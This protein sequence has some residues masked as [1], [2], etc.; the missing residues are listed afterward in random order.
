MEE[1]A[2]AV[3][4]ILAVYWVFDIEFNPKSKKTLEM[5]CHLMN[6]GGVIQSVA[7]QRIINKL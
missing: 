4:I 1:V 6:V 7:V 5:Y 2:D 3:A